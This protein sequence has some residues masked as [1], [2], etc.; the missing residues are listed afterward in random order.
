MAKDS[1]FN[2]VEM[3]N[4]RS[5]EQLKGEGAEEE[6]GEEGGR[7]AV[8]QEPER[9]EVMMIDV[10]DLIPSVENFYQVDDSLKRSIELAGILQ[11]LL[12]NRPENGKYK[13]IAG[14][15]RRLAVLSLVKEGKEKHRYV[16]CVYK[17]EGVMDKLALIMANRFRDKSD[18]EK[19]REIVE[20]EE[21]A[22]ELKRDHGMEGRTRDVL[23]QIMGV[24][25]AQI[26][27][28]KAVYS[29]LG[30]GLMEPFKDGTLSFSVASELCGLPTEWQKKAERLMKGNGTL[31]LADVRELKEQKGREKRGKSGTDQKSPPQRSDC[32]EQRGVADVVQ[33]DVAQGEPDLALEERRETG[34]HPTAPLAKPDSS[35]QAGSV[36]EEQKEEEEPDQSMGI[37][38]EEREKRF[39][40][41]RGIERDDVPLS[42][43]S[44]RDV[45]G[46]VVK[47][48]EVCR[49]RVYVCPTAWNGGEMG[50]KEYRKYGC[51]VCEM[52]GNRHFF[53]WGTGNCP[54]C[55]INLSWG[56]EDSEGGLSNGGN[57]AAGKR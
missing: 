10:E 36:Y 43:V 27:R 32:L 50:E 34:N 7:A 25:Q 18:W 46:Y 47:A 13:V 52:F 11:P 51:P 42:A 8:D 16:P 19:M 45:R 5:K 4:R 54:L 37:S 3:L 15:R 2:L 6:R 22:R 35:C 30:Q 56:M 26:G 48:D 28:Y 53:S 20:A 38:G 31:T 57:E 44:Y 12:V 21:L 23:S 17:E 39:S 49:R 14:H 40:G 1:G 9:Q 33:E 29:N 55:G 24:S 41:K